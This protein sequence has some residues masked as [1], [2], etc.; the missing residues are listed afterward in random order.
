M[1]WFGNLKIRVKLI[2]CFII[3]A[4][5]TGAVGLIGIRNMGNINESVTKMYQ[6]NYIPSQKLALIQ[7]NLLIVRSD[8]L[9]MLYERDATLFQKRADEI[10]EAANLTN[11]ILTE[12]EVNLQ[13]EE[14][15]SIFN[16]IESCLTAYR[17]Q[18]NSN[19]ELIKNQ[20]FEKAVE[21]TPALTKDREALDQAVE[22]LITYNSE[23]AQEEAG[24]ND[25]NYKFNSMVMIAIIAIGIVLSITLGVIVANVIA[26]PL[27]KLLLAADKIANGDLDVTVTS[28]TK[29]EVGNL[30]FAFK[31]MVDNLNEV[32][33]NI[34]TA[35]EQVAAGSRQVSDSSMALSQGATEQASSVQEL[36]SSL[37][38]I[39]S[40]TEKNA[41]SANKANTLAESA[42]DNALQG[43]NQMNDMLKAM[44]EINDSSNNISKIIKVIDEIAFQTNILALNAAVEAARAGQHGKGF[45]VVAEEVRNLAARSA[46][47]AKE[48]T[49]MIESSIKKVDGGTKIAGRTA[50][51]LNKI[52]V[53][54]SK[55]ADLVSDIATASSEQAQGIA[56]I[57]QGIMQVSDVV[58]ANSATSQE[59]AAASEELSSQAEMLKD[60]VSRFKLRKM[61]YSSPTFGNLQELNPD[62]LKL[63]ESMPEKQKA[64]IYRN[65]IKHDREVANKPKRIILDDKEFGKY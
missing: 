37:E 23:F 28:E 19:I 30:A 25:K 17:E 26:K 34:S 60:Q 33:Q 65:E 29:D 7:K 55:V 9:L 44:D 18:R 11:E 21:L 57:N 5:L 10:S 61:Q 14:E 45:A 15:K 36:T 38:E 27:N 42:K 58:Q 1:K 8:Y 56:Q 3:L 49:E 41:E 53:D 4:I 2:T 35:A 6:N 40:Q 20:Q 47:A 50:E 32:M 12:L 13:T 54:I 24:L 43:N 63:L 31:K 39:A 48:T 46:N 59:S 51:A 52:V 62:I 64:S 22:R 16:E